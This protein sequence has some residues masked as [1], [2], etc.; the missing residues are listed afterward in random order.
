MVRYAESARALLEQGEIQATDVVS[1]ACDALAA[2]LD[3]PAVQILAACTRAE[4]DHDVPQLLPLA[5]DELGRTPC[6]SGMAGQ[7]AEERALA[8]WM[9]AGE[10]A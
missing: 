5:L 1:G 7:E 10:L 3:R 6:H 9:P 8:A 2:G 4:A